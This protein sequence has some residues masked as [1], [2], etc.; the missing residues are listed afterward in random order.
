MNLCDQPFTIMRGLDLV[1]HICPVSSHNPKY[2]DKRI[3]RRVGEKWQA[4][5]FSVQGSNES[6]VM[7]IFPFDPT[8]K[9]ISLTLAAM[10]NSP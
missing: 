4:L 9:A 5:I 2:S 7:T 6:N 1:V 10:S 8:T 3:C